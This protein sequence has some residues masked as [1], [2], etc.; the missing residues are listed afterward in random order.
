MIIWFLVQGHDASITQ[1]NFDTKEFKYAELE[2]IFQIKHRDLPPFS[3]ENESGTLDKT[4]R[5]LS[6]LVDTKWFQI[7]DKLVVYTLYPNNRAE[8]WNALAKEMGRKYNGFKLIEVRGSQNSDPT[9]QHHH[10]HQISAYYASPFEN[11]LIYSHDGGG[12]DT[13]TGMSTCRNKIFDNITEYKQVNGYGHVFNCLGFLCKNYISPHVKVSDLSEILDYPGKVM[14]LSSYGHRL[15]RPDEVD[16][17]KGLMWSTFNMLR[18]RQN[19]PVMNDAHAMPWNLIWENKTQQHPSFQFKERKKIWNEDNEIYH[20]YAAQ[21]AAEEFTVEFLSTPHIKKLLREHDNNLVITGGSAFNVIVNEVVKEQLS[22]NVFVPPDPGDQNISM[23]IA[24]KYLTEHG[25]DVEKQFKLYSD[26]PLEDKHR[27]QEHFNYWKNHKNAE[28]ITV[29][30]LAKKLKEGKVIGIVEGNVEKGPRALG[31]RSILCDPSYPNARDN[32][33]LNI[34]KREWYRP[35]APVCRKEVADEH[36]ISTNFDNTE[37]MSFAVK[38]TQRTAIKYPSVVHVD[39]TARLQTVT[40]ESN[41]FV[42][43]LLE[44]FDMLLNTSF[45]VAGKPILNSIHTALE[46]LDKTDLDYVAVIE[47]EEIYLFSTKT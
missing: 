18:W 29:E 31:H 37:W 46:F 38:A 13:K 35:F 43:S 6:R 30:N 47:N 5:F 14:G 36:F 41:P 20:C 4:V 10:M 39:G 22:C 19:K 23:G 34:K 32:V 12:D 16:Y 25:I 24:I 33:N 27:L 9:W 3:A 26:F 1:Y 42:Y 15:K 2:K 7:P 11:A 28:K 44:H 21:K 8:P 17:Y 40:K 45:N